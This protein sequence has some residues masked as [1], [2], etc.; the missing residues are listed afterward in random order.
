MFS[1]DISALKKIILPAQGNLENAISSLTSV[2]DSALKR[3]E[4]FTHREVA[5]LKERMGKT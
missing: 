5:D 1:N 4:D 3:L 2:T